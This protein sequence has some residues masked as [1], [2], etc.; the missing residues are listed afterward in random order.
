MFY[1][2]L[3]RPLKAAA[4]LGGLAPGPLPFGGKKTFIVLIGGIFN[5]KNML[6]TK[7]L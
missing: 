6:K 4:Y 1:T 3:A 2:F 5:V 7:H